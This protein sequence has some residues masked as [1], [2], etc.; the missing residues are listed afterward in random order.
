M[1]YAEIEENEVGFRRLERL[2]L[3]ARQTPQK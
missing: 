2:R 1:N 3:H